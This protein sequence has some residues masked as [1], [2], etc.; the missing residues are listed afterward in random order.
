[1]ADQKNNTSN[2]A[3]IGWGI[4][5]VVFGCVF[6]LFWHFFQY[7]I[8]NAFR[9]LRYG[10]MWIV[11]WFVDD[12]Y[13][14]RYQGNDYG[15]KASMPMFKNASPHDL[16]GHYSTLAYFSMEP[17]KW[18]FI[19][20][21]AVMAYWAYTRGPGTQYRRRLDL[22]GL[23][24]AQAPTFP[25]IHPFIKFNPS[26]QKPRPPGAPVPAELPLFAEAL[27]PEEWLAYNQI[28]IPDGHVSEQES[29]IAFARQ[30]GPRWQG[31]KALAPY[32]Q[33]LLAAFCL[34]ASRKRKEAD[35]LLGRLA[36]CW[37]E[38]GMHLGHDKSLAAEARKILKDEKLSG[39]TLAK[40]NNHA[41]ETTAL[42]RALQTAREEGG[43]MAPAQFVWMR[44]HDRL[45]WYPL[46]NLGRQAFHMEALGAM[47]HFK[48]EKLTQR[49]IPKPKVDN[50]I[51]SISNY[52][53]S[54]RARP[55]PQLDYT[56]SKKHGVKKPKKK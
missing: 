39:K 2:D 50:A 31:W 43:V 37:S 24:R 51:L 40:C 30:L 8:K 29:Y 5:L 55:V 33:V 4:L 1:M 28:P 48:S 32:R 26:L 9:W 47:S 41:F 44:A 16:D 10:E 7:Q 11:S 46:N 21:L 17:M 3:A 20:I 18:P 45:L 25:V 42:L 35:A 27:G 49:P 23:I 34:K 15:F 54:P 6:L 19:A 14:V 38:K 22:D 12:N 36:S 52:M 56:D 13:T 53:R